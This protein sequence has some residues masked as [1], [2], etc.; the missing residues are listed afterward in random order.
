MGKVNFPKNI[1]DEEPYQLINDAE[2]TL[3]YTMGD[4][5]KK[6]IVSTQ[7]CNPIYRLEITNLGY[8][9]NILLEVFIPDE[10]WIEEVL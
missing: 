8:R 10:E 1:S 3:I 5:L 9:G 4:R 2:R 6:N 7:T